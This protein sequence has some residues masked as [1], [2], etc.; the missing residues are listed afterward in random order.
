MGSD[1]LLVWLEAPGE[2]VLGL[3]RPQ[4]VTTP[5]APWFGG[6]FLGD[7]GEDTKGSAMGP[8]CG[9]VPAGTIVSRVQRSSCYHLDWRV[10]L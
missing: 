9:Q 6:L 5:L 3:I 7:E 1:G 8:L 4:R 10:D 2:V